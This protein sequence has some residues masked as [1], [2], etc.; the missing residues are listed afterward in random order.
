MT[1]IHRLKS[2]GGNNK[3]L[4]LILRLHNVRRLSEEAIFGNKNGQL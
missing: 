4:A 1:T 2:T 3:A